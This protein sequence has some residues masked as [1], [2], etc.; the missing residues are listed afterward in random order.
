MNSVDGDGQA[1][2]AARNQSLFRHVTERIEALNEEFA[3][4]TPLGEWICECA[5]DA[6]FETMSLTSANTK[7]SARR[8]ARGAPPPPRP[9][10]DP[11]G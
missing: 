5:D 11:A 3:R 8:A 9:S 4:I 7:G 6:C 10:A 1:V 2:Q